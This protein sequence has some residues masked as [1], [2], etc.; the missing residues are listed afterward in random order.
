MFVFDPITGQVIPVQTGGLTTNP[1][2]NSL[3][4]AVNTV[5]GVAVDPFTG[6]PLNSF[7]LPVNPAIDN[8]A[9]SLGIFPGGNLT[10]NP[11]VNSLLGATNTVTSG[12]P[13]N[14]DLLNNLLG[15]ANTLVVESAPLINSFEQQLFNTTSQITG[16][17]LGSIDLAD[18]LGLG[19][20]GIPQEAILNPL[21]LNSP[22]GQALGLI[23]GLSRNPI[24]PSLNALSNIEIIND[25]LEI[26]MI[27]RQQTTFGL[28]DASNAI[29]D[30]FNVLVGSNSLLSSP[31]F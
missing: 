16:G 12:I 13:S 26:D 21:S 4:G 17:N 6:Q 24:N 8:L 30:G 1:Q 9:A 5:S 2:L 28:N 14:T 22:A 7:G 3:F 23:S 19:D 25:Q 31:F 27:N 10:T 11:T 18:P 15:Q 20:L 29:V